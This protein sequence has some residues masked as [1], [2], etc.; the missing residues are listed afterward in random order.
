MTLVTIDADELTRL[1]ADKA[2]LQ[3]VVV[4]LTEELQV[5]RKITDGHDAE[6]DAMADL[7]VERWRTIQTLEARCASLQR[8][9]LDLAVGS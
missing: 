1:R 7:A 8:Q 5:L 6:A 3:G 9:V 4:R 2:A